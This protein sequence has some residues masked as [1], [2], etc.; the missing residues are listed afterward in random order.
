MAKR[1]SYYKGSKKDLMDDAIPDD[2]EY[3]M[4]TEGNDQYLVPKKRK[5][6]KKGSSGSVYMSGMKPDGYNM[7]SSG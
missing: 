5:K 4:V 3:E 7:S 6:K 1:K 2:D